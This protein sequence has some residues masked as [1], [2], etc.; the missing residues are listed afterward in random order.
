[1]LDTNKELEN[2]L[3]KYFTENNWI[4]TKKYKINYYFE[5]NNNWIGFAQNKQYFSIYLANYFPLLE[6]LKKYEG[7]YIK[8]CKSAIKIY[9]QGEFRLQIYN[10]IINWIEK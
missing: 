10:D 7:K 3:I 5:K 6:Y 4:N 1:M 9:P 8:F 2:K